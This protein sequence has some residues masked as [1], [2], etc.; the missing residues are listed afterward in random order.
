M[1]ANRA[2]DCRRRWYFIFIFAECS[3]IRIDYIDARPG[4]RIEIVQLSFRL[5]KSGPVYWRW[6]FCRAEIIKT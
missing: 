5:D 6:F 1:H 2:T 3:E 4:L